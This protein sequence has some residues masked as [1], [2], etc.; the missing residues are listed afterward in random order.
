MRYL[1]WLALALV[2][3]TV[4]TWA[5]EAPQKP[6]SL[7]DA[8]ALALKQNPNLGAVREDLPAALARLKMAQAE[9]KLTGSASALPLDGHRGQHAGRAGGRHAEDGH[10]GP[11]R[12]QR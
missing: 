8:V 3:P 6:L 10:D 7:A 12:G 11:A 5:A 1:T 9:G 2:L 4:V